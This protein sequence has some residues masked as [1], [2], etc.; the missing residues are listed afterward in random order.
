MTK[1]K[2][3]PANGHVSRLGGACRTVPIIVV[4]ILGPKIR[5]YSVHILYYTLI[6]FD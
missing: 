5:Y 1:A 4:P 6:K 3:V 2:L